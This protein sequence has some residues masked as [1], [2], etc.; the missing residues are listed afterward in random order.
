MKKKLEM[1][2]EEPIMVSQEEL[3]YARNTLGV[4]WGYVSVCPYG[5]YENMGLAVYVYN[6]T[7]KQQH[8]FFKLHKYIR[9]MIK[10]MGPVSSS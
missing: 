10:E 6:Y 9:L 5:A 2:N 1:N 3:H 4:T 8:I 7:N